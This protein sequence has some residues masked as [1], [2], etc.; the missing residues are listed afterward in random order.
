VKVTQAR[1]LV[2]AVKG[3]AAWLDRGRVIIA[4]EYGTASIPTNVSGQWGQIPLDMAPDM[5]AGAGNVSDGIWRDG[6]VERHVTIGQ[7]APLFALLTS[8]TAQPFTID[9]ARAK[10]LTAA[11]PDRQGTLARPGLAQAVADNGRLFVTDRYC[12]HWLPIDGGIYGA[13]PV[14]V[15]MYAATHDANIVLE[16]DVWSVEGHGVQITGH[17]LGDAPNVSTVIDAAFQRVRHDLPELF[18]RAAIDAQRS[19]GKV[20]VTVEYGDTIT[21]SAGDASLTMPGFTPPAPLRVNA[22]YIEQAH[23][24]GMDWFMTDTDRPIIGHASDRNVLVMP[25][26]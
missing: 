23:V 15:F 14:S 2:R 18:A 22:A 25:A 16:G 12:L 19:L 17:S 21:A 7:E 20:R 10:W 11:A 1:A 9:K 5:V 4:G 3:R 26:R 13:I 6:N 8:A 24:P